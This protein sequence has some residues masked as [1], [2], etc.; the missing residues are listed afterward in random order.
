MKRIELFK[1]TGI[2][3][4]ALALSAMVGAA[5]PLMT[6]FAADSSTTEAAASAEEGG[7]QNEN[8]DDGGGS[9]DDSGSGSDETPTESTLSLIHI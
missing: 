7:D 8:T 2:C 6:A 3:F 5:N 1:K 9:T 4:T